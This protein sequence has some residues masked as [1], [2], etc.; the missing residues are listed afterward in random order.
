MSGNIG[1][2]AE[3]QD[4]NA[5][6]VQQPAGSISGSGS[7]AGGAAIFDKSTIEKS[8]AV[9]AALMFSPGI[10][11]LAAPQ[12]TTTGSTNS[13]AATS[14]LSNVTNL[15]MDVEKAKN[16][17]I[18]SMWDNFL[19]NV[20]EM[21]KRAKEEDIKKW[22]EDVNKNGPKSGAEYQAFLMAMSST[23][24]AQ[25]LSG[26]NENALSVQ[27]NQTF[28]TWLGSPAASSTASVAAADP[29]AYPSSH[30]VAGAVESNPDV[31]RNAIGAVGAQ[32]GVQL[33][34][35]PVADALQ[36]VGPTTG[37]PAD[38]QA[39]AGLVASLLNGGAVNKAT[40]DTVSDAAK[41]G[42]PVIDLNFALN[43]AKNVMKIVTHNVEGNQPM[44]NE[45]ASQN[46][47]MR[48]MLTAMA[49][50]MVYRTAY[51][52]IT[53]QEFASMLDPNTTAKLPE[54]IKQ[55]VEDLAGLLQSYLPDDPTQKTNILM[56]LMSLADKNESF[57][58]MLATSRLYTSQLQTGDINNTRFKS[59]P[60]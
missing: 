18:S 55:T 9:A 1:G 27:F 42:Q 33:S 31:V 20:H 60:A 51:G 30:F 21:A 41:K 38:Y 40:T 34:V 43:Y 10:P 58:T 24:R 44:N 3:T 53:G 37:L 14:S 28:N 4:P 32:A 45:Q 36:A 2:F 23:Q 26:G 49:L 46:N 39:A 16:D 25:E 6:F 50:I 11:L 35:S 15:Q 7:T 13:V 59:A 29:T 56:N 5:A 17:I 57:D 22:T 8:E 47:M 48:I 12:D 19:D 52:G 54:Q